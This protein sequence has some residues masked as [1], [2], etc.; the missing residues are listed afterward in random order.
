MFW[1]NLNKIKNWNNNVY[2]IRVSRMEVSCIHSRLKENNPEKTSIRE[3]TDNYWYDVHIVKYCDVSVDCECTTKKCERESDINCS[4]A[5]NSVA[6]LYC[7]RE[8]I[9]I[10]DDNQLTRVLCGIKSNSFKIYYCN[11]RLN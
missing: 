7:A 1:W 9:K 8:L 5:F 2:T 4:V 3:V 10:L 11:L 6:F